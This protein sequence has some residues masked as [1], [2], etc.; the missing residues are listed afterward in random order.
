MNS[1]KCKKLR[2]M[3]NKGG[4]EKVTLKIIYKGDSLIPWKGFQT[5]F[6][7]PSSSYQRIYKDIKKGK[8]EQFQ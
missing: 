7:Y 3:L 5:T 1:K 4:V 2:R 8:G 6:K